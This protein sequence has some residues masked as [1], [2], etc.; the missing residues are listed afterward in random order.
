VSSP[1]HSLFDYQALENKDT[2][3]C[4]LSIQIGM[5]GLSFCIRHKDVILA[6]ESYQ[7][8][9]SQLEDT[10]KNH[11]WLLKDYASINIGLVTKKSTL[12]PTSTYDSSLKETYLSFNH[13][14]TEKLEVIEDKIESIDSVNLYGIS[15]AERNIIN[16]FFSK[17][18]I[19][20]YGSSLIKT[21]MHQNKNS[22]E[23]KL[24]VSIQDSHMEV[25]AIG[26]SKLQFFNIFQHSNAQ[27]VAYNILFVVEQLN[28]NP[29]N[30]LLVLYGETEKDS[31]IY[32]LMYTYIR[33]IEY[34]KNKEKISPV[35]SDVP[36]HFYF[37][38]IHQQICE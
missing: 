16:T 9:L 7:H 22:S 32:N 3:D 31:E 15:V 37:N 24:L 38:L 29:E 14:R 26:S 34:G 4:H 12:I 1:I 30:I 8:P 36:E 18:T 10:I 25:A 21:W 19:K 2:K 6:I 33:N 27:D 20:H 13:N 23:Q 28:L 5:H 11:K 35:I 17:A